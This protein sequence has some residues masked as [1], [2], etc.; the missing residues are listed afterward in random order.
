VNAAVVAVGH[1]LPHGALYLGMSSMSDQYH[2][3]SIATATGNFEMHFGYQRAGG[4]EYTQLALFCFFAD[5]LGDA[6]GTEYHA[7]SIWHIA[8]FINKNGSP[9]A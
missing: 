8:Q 3:V 2:L 1:A 7:V 5:R 6:V 4:I 9:G